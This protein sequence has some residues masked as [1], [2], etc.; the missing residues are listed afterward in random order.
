MTRTRFSRPFG[1]RATV[2]SNPAVNCRAILKS[3]SGRSAGLSA[4]LNANQAA[5]CQ[6]IRNSSRDFG[7]RLTAAVPEG[8]TIIAQRFNAGYGGLNTRESRRDER[9]LR[10][11]LIQPSL[12][13]SLRYWCLNPALKRRA[14]LTV[15]LRDKHPLEFPKGVRAIFKSPPG[16]TERRMT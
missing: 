2:D 4:T 11:K 3:P 9:K 15:S 7:S 6:G 8:Q 14:I 13:D 10:S 5:N 12:R 16:R 1:T